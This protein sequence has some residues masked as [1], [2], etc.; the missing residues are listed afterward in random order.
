MLTFES[1]AMSAVASWLQENGLVLGVGI[2][3]GSI[4]TITTVARA[5]LR[6]RREGAL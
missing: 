3:I 2:L 6:L 5:L 1:S 4:V